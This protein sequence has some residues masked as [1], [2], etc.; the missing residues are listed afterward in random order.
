MM[1]TQSGAPRVTLGLAELAV[2]RNKGET[3]IT[4][5]LGSCLGITLYDPVAQVAGMLHVMLPSSSIDAEKARTRPGMFVDTGVPRLFH[6]AYRLG[7]VKS[8]IIVKIAGG[9]QR[10]ATS[11]EAIATRNIAAVRKI[12][13]R[14]KMLITR[15]DVGGD[16]P[17]T[18]SI[19]VTTGAV[20]IKSRGAS[21]VL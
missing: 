11:G 10:M 8:R 21:T 14:N 2:S 7:A 15:M 4:Y 1:Q 6:S 19:D 18:M 3:L 17:R 12:M 13:W 16:Q 5:A 20:H 9:M